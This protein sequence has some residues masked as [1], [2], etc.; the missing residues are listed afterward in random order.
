MIELPSYR[1]IAVLTEGRLGVFSSKTA[2]M[3]LR[4]RAEDVV[5]VVD[6]AAA[7]SDVTAAI[8][9]ARPVPILADV[10]ELP[11]MGCDALF[12]GVAPVGG[13][14]PSAMRGHVLNAAKC[15]ID[16]VSGMHA[17]LADDPELAAAAADGGARLFDVRRPPAERLVA[18]ARARQTRCR[19]VLTVGTD[20]N[21][22]K[23]FT[24][25]E[26]VASLKRRGRNA[27]FAA[28]GQTG[29][30]VCG[31]GIVVDA[32]VADFVAG[33]AEALVLD[34]DARGAELCVVEGQGSLGHPSFSAVTLGLLHGVCPDAL[35]LV[36][37]LGRTGYRAHPDL[38]L[39]PIDRLIRAYEGVSEL[40]S[41]A[42]VV[43]IAVN[44]TGVD[45]ET[46]EREVAWLR[47]VTGLPV[48][49]PR[50]ESFP[51]EI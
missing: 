31:R 47:G 24:A 12:V 6:S 11:A 50:R 34:A 4:Y 18:G 44:A 39:P 3:L 22:G 32:V 16:V 20:C 36:H 27:A 2:A 48:Y 41:A 49:D 8:P 43:A 37:H 38:P 29:I 5:A 51:G 28:T 13:E 14:L 26:L 10:D 45:E 9:W 19:R 30:M 1:R 17:F 15:G 33:A 40:V 7:G 23:M 35:V 21:V 25:L 42:K 46:A